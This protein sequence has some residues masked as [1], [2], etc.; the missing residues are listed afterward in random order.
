MRS[1]SAKHSTAMFFGVN[2]EILSQD[3][4]ITSIKVSVTTD[5]T[6]AG[7]NLI[8]FPRLV[9]RAIEKVMSIVMIF[10]TGLY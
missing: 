5:I 10:C 1:R 6:Q 2:R 3:F 8:H 4:T 7:T 9:E